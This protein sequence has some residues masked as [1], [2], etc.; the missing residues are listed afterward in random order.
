MQIN[1]A[2]TANIEE[3]AKLFDSYRQ[4]YQCQPD[5]ELSRRFI[6][7][8]LKNDESTIFIALDDDS[9]ARGFVQ[10]Y[11]SFCSIDACKILILHD[12]YVDAELRNRGLG[13]L[14]MNRA[15]EYASETGV[16]RIDLLTSKTNYSGQALYE[17]LGY[18]KTLEDYFAYSL[19]P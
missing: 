17:K 2:T 19:N 5:I 3:I 1:Q 10:L 15:R 6:G 9:K 14:L 18:D 13:K 12:L 4:F 7:D 16:G 11:A 8:R